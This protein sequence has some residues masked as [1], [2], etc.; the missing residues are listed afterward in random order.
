[1]FI[2]IIILSHI[3]FIYLHIY[4]GEPDALLFVRRY[5]IQTTAELR[6]R[7]VRIS[8]GHYIPLLRDQ[9]CLLTAYVC[10]TGRCQQKYRIKDCKQNKATPKYLILHTVNAIHVTVVSAIDRQSQ[11]FSSNADHGN[12]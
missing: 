4:Y 7:V 2:I 9:P 5:D 8:R 11:M 6:W 3:F 1:M 12:R 10:H